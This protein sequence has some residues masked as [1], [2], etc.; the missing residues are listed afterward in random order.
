MDSYCLL[1]IA[2]S[3]L[4]KRTPPSTEHEGSLPCSHQPRLLFWT[5][6]IQPTLSH[7]SSITSILILSYLHQ[8]LPS[9]FLP[10]DFQTKI[11]CAYLRSHACY[12]SHPSHISWFCPP[13]NI[14][15]EYKL[16]ILA[17]SP[18]LKKENKFVT[19]PC[20]PSLSLS[21]SLCP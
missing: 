5:K 14:G 18:F 10:S 16:C 19:S 11:L 13:N 2:V 6:W 17:H 20:C 1:K 4:V 21:L 15:E 12:T 9:G 8:N 3:H 7:P